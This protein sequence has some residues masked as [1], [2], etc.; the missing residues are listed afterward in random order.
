M[1]KWAFATHPT[2]PRLLHVH[3][4]I[5]IPKLQSMDA[6][7]VL[8][9]DVAVKALLSSDSIFWFIVVLSAKGFAKV[10]FCCCWLPEEDLT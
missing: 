5:L 6:L 4:S 10:G 8:S 9:L 3:R 2:S 7:A 1:I